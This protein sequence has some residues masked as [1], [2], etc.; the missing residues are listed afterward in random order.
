MWGVTKEPDLLVWRVVRWRRCQQ[1]G[2]NLPR[3]WIRFDST[4]AALSGR[5]SEFPRH[6]PNLDGARTVTFYVSSGARRRGGGDP[7]HSE[8]HV[9]DPTTPTS[10]QTPISMKG[11]NLFPTA[12]PARIGC[13]HREIVNMPLKS[14]ETIPI[15][16][17]S[18]QP[19]R[20][21]GSVSLSPR[22]SAPVC[23]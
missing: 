20:P 22:V 13:R 8:R 12:N 19:R 4:L 15:E 10:P 2:S 17:Q 23:L 6:T 11:T 9:H 14:L 21:A 16:V 5:G 7:S 1:N 3:W 18:R